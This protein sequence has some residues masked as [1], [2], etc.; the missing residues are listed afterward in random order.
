MKPVLQTETA[1]LDAA[2]C[3][4]ALPPLHATPHPPQF[5]LSVVSSTQVPL[6][7]LGGLLHSQAPATQLAPVGHV[8][9]HAPQF[10][11]SS[12]SSTHEAPHLESPVGQTQVPPAQCWPAAHLLLHAPQLFESIVKSA[13]APLQMA[14][15]SVPVASHTQAPFAQSAPGGHTLPQWPQLSGS[16]LVLTHVIVVP[17]AP[18][19]HIDVAPVQ[20]QI[21]LG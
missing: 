6:H 5:L 14:A 3:Q 20:V 12:A 15:T 10:A 4:V 17:A 21:P 7:M 11:L 13:Q 16:V 2:Q 1:Q 8:L 18:M 19:G 9:P